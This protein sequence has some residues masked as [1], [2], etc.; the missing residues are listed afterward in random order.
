MI[1]YYSKSSEIRPDSCFRISIIPL[2]GYSKY[3]TEV[4]VDLLETKLPGE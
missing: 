1:L 4:D 3:G 2:R